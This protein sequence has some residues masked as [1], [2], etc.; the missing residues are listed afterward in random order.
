TPN[1]STV[2]VFGMPRRADLE[3]VSVNGDTA[4][5]TGSLDMLDELK[6][7]AWGDDGFSYLL[8]EGEAT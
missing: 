5:V 4:S 6:I 1:A 3:S 2:Q 7:Y 8:Y